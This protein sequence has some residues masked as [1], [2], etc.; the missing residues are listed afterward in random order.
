MA[1]TPG[2]RGWDRHISKP[3]A[4]PDLVDETQLA[5][6]LGISKLIFRRLRKRGPLPSPDLRIGDDDLWE[7]EPVREWARYPSPVPR[8][9]AIQ[10]EPLEVDLVDLGEI[11]TRFPV[12]LRVIQ[13]W[14]K[15]QRLPPP[16]YSFASG[17]AWLWSTIDKWRHRT[18]L[19]IAG[20]RGPKG[21]GEARTLR[22]LVQE[23]AEWARRARFDEAEVFFTNLNRQLRDLLN[24]SRIEPDTVEAGPASAQSPGAA[25][26]AGVAS[27]DDLFYRLDR[28]KAQFADLA[29]QLRDL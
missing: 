26:A 23:S 11:A 16:D 25:K 21:N 4:P 12:S 19:P 20:R 22:P 14:H 17:E 3:P 18:R 29:A 5:D 28:L 2:G 6:R 10:R 13:G 8:P 24:E 9:A 1:Y 15:Q 27:A 7:W